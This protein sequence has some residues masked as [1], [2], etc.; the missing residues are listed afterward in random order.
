MSVYALIVLR[1]L[2]VFD[3]LLMLV[4]GVLL[5]CFMAAP[6][7]ILFGAGCWLVSGM[8]FGGVRWADRLYDRRS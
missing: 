8:L 4:V 3:A 7:G 2:M 1:S 5:A 6:P